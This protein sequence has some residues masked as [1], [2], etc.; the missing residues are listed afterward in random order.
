MSHTCQSASV[1]PIRCPDRDKEHQRMHLDSQAAL[2]SKHAKR[3]APPWRNQASSKPPAHRTY[4]LTQY[5]NRVTLT[6]LAAYQIDVYMQIYLQLHRSC[7]KQLLQ[8]VKI[9]QPSAAHPS[10]C[11]YF[12]ESL[13]VLQD[14]VTSCCQQCLKKGHAIYYRLARCKCHP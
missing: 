12:G 3:Q 6:R 9:P 14:L 13:S 2:N 7:P 4:N 5:I 11:T 8:R 1:R 10:G